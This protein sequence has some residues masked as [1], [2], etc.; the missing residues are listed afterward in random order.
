[1]R[2]LKDEFPKPVCA[3][4][5]ASSF[6]NEGPASWMRTVVLMSKVVCN[7]LYAFLASNRSYRESARHR[8]TISDLTRSF[9]EP[10][11]VKLCT[12]TVLPALTTDVAEFVS[13]AAPVDNRRLALTSKFRSRECRLTLCDCSLSEAQSYS[14][15][16]NSV[17]TLL[18]V[19][20]LRLLPHY[21]RLGSLHRVLAS[22]KA[23][24][25]VCRTVA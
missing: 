2:A 23:H 21:H 11:F 9:V 13:T 8:M 25:F 22:C 3:F 16:K 10:S 24:T 15:T 6:T 4:L 7:L 18:F 20:T 12:F 17:A 19:T 14:C 1:M 5:T